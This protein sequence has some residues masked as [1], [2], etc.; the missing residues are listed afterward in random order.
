MRSS[1]DRGVRLG[2]AA[3]VVLSGLAALA[4]A[5]NAPGRASASAGRDAP[6]AVDPR[7]T[8]PPL[9]PQPTPAQLADYFR[10]ISARNVGPQRVRLRAPGSAGGPGAPAPNEQVLELGSAWKGAAP[11][12]VKPLPVDVFTSKDFYQDRELWSDPR[13]FRCN[14]PAALEA[15]RGTS[16]TPLVANGDPSTAPWGYCD[17]D[18][19]REALV[20]P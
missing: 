10:Q 2:I 12:G 7:V 3:V 16:G 15:Q 19:P 5:Q 6:L 9:P 4:V 18:L 11:K 20:S 8:V 13:Y 1:I 17:R 14:S